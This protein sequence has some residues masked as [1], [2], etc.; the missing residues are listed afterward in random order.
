MERLICLAIGYVC[1]LFQTSYIIGRMHKTD[2]REHGSGN[3]GTTNALR[4]FGKKAGA[5]TLIGDLMKCVIAVWIVKALFKNSYGDILPLLSLYAGAGCILGHNFPFYLNFRGGKGVAASVGMVIA[6]DWKL[7]VL[8][9][10]V[11]FGIFFATHYVSLCS[12]CAYI[13]ALIVMIV[14]GRMGYYGMDHD[15]TL[16]MYIVMAVLTV[17][18]FYRHRANIGRLVNG[19]ENKIYLGGKSGKQKD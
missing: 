3:A 13:S 12:L 7:F 16:E 1:G 2:I 15:H 9:A 14:F 18:A 17:L 6:F 5:M 11:F 4:T 19:T 8:C 10:I